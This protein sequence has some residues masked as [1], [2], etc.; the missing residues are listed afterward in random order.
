MQAIVDYTGRLAAF[1]RNA[2]LYLLSTVLN[3]FGFSVSVLLLN[4]YILSLGYRQDFVGLLAAIPSFVAMFAAIPA[5]MVGDWLG[6]KRTLVVGAALTGLALAGL[7][8]STDKLPLILFSILSGAGPAFTFIIGP[9]FMAENSSEEERTHLFSVQF[10]LSTF[11]GV[12]GSLVGGSLPGLTRAWFGFAPE[13]AAVYRTTLLVAAGVDLTAVLPLL[14]LQAKEAP[15]RLAM[16]P[17]SGAARW[18]HIS[19]LL[20]TELIIG[21]G[22][23]A[24]MPFMNVFFRLKFAVPD[25]ALGALFAGGSVAIGIA[26]LVGPVLVNRLGKVRAVVA[27]QVASIP[28]LLILGFSLNLSSVVIAY[29][30][31]GAL[32]NMGGPIFSAFA[33][34]QV[35]ANERATTSSLLEVVWSI[36]WTVGPWASGLVQVAYGFDP[37]FLTTTVCY[38]VSAML[39]FAFFGKVGKAAGVKPAATDCRP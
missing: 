18:G 12:V 37:V 21:L 25:E 7:A 4:L 23:G 8:T 19:K 38:A 5:G 22:A 28:F 36:G 30:V 3:G 2:R 34:E 26:T 35:E 11:A 24:L 10:A 20:I 13:S 6:R 39:L 14:L 1:S 16:L 31:R 9:P 27:T 32:M 33:M 17:W 15:G 29:L